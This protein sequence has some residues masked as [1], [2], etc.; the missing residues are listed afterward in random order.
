MKDIVKYSDYL[1]SPQ[2]SMRRQIHLDQAANRCQLCNQNGNTLDVHHKTYERVGRERFDDL[3]VLCRS[4]H[5]RVHAIIEDRQKESQVGQIPSR[6]RPPSTSKL[7]PPEIGLITPKN[8]RLR[9]LQ[10]K[11]ACAMT[12][13]LE[14]SR[15]DAAEEIA[16]LRNK[17]SELMTSNTRDQ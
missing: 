6:R 12:D 14:T 16:Y 1:E 4:C 10:R 3:I 7:T 8:L 5:N 11:L 13:Y 15:K 17:L 2:W 9:L